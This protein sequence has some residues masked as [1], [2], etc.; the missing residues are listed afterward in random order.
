MIRNSKEI[1]QILDQLDQDVFD[2][3]LEHELELNEIKTGE[4][5]L[6]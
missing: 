4:E 2:Y 5:D 6:I 3:S 1:L